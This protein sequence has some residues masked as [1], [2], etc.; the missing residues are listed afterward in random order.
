M[1]KGRRRQSGF[2]KNRAARAQVDF[3]ANA[4]GAGGFQKRKVDR[5]LVGSRLGAIGLLGASNVRKLNPSDLAELLPGLEIVRYGIGG[6]TSIDLL[7]HADLLI[8]QESQ[9]KAMIIH[10]GTNDLKKRYNRAVSQ[11]LNAEAIANDILKLA[12]RCKD[13]GI[14][15]IY[16]S[17]ISPTRI[18]RSNRLAED[19][20]RKLEELVKWRDNFYFI[21]NWHIHEGFLYDNVHLTDHGLKLLYQNYAR[22]LGRTLR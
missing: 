22:I 2:T 10:C 16:I 14:P 17:G 7:R 9:M 1:G 4:V 8:H 12:C 11:E 19:I 6:A 21:N 20:N 13:A 15:K 3:D 5:C 18:S